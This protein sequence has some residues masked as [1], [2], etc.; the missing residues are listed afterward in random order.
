MNKCKGW[1]CTG[2]EWVICMKHTWVQIILITPITWLVS[3][4]NSFW[5]DN[6][7]QSAI[8][9]QTVQEI[10]QT[11]QD[12]VIYCTVWILSWGSQ[13]IRIWD[14]VQWKINNAN[15]SVVK[16][17]LSPTG[18]Q[19][20]P[21]LDYPLVG[22]TEPKCLYLDDVKHNHISGGNKTIWSCL[23]ASTAISVTADHPCSVAMS[24][25]IMQM[26]AL[27]TFSVNECH[28]LHFAPLVLG[29]F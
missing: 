24:R 26:C 27:A 14:Y 7:S 9:T 6:T 28:G 13:P 11:V 17:I 8:F 5:H 15:H 25:D 23:W 12:Y 21:W 19:Y 4:K 29:S 18:V 1:L 10:T 22:S 16:L 2:S 20:Q 3:V